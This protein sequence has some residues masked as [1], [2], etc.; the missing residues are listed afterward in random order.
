MG[1]DPDKNSEYEHPAGADGADRPQDAE[2]EDPAIPGVP[3]CPNCGWRNTRP[4]HQK[5]I[6]DTVLRTFS[7]RPYRCRSC[8]NRFRVMRRAAH[9]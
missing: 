6:L 2:E 3:M 8:G 1:K 5:T 9:N 7:F 4:S